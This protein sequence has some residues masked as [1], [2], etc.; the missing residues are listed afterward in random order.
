MTAAAVDAN[1]NVD[2]MACKGYTELIDITPNF[3]R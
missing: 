2:A 3:P 1:C